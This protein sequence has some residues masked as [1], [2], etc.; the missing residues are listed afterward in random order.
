MHDMPVASWDIVKHMCCTL[1]VMRSCALWLSH[2]Q[3]THKHLNARVMCDIATDTT[4]H[5][6]TETVVFYDHSVK[7]V[8]SGEFMCSVT[9][10]SKSRFR[11]GRVLANTRDA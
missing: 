3:I 5:V 1:V 10:H 6:L 11:A 7:H 4:V 8:S 2:K 9:L